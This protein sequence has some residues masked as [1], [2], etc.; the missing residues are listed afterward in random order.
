M[1]TQRSCARCKNTL[2]KKRAQ[3]RKRYCFRCEHLTRRESKAKAH[4]QRVMT[5]YGL[6]PGEY[7]LLLKAQDGSCAVFNCRAKGVTKYL[8]VEHDHKLTGRVS[9]RGLMCSMHNGWIGRAGDDPRVFDSIAAY[10][11]DPP[12]RKVLL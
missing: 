2:T 10:L 8:A 3:T 6:R 4:E 11:R 5:V 1:I 9:V 12:A 7:D